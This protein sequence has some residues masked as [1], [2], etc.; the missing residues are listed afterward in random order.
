M[1]KKS[2]GTYR[3]RLNA[4]GYEQHEGV[5]YNLRNQELSFVC[6]KMQPTCA[7]ISSDATDLESENC[8]T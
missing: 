5:H 6:P 7:R 3:A 1:K 2:N 8:S 4:R